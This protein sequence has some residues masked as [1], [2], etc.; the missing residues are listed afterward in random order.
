M[1]IMQE[2]VALN[3]TLFYRGMLGFQPR[4]RKALLDFQQQAVTSG[5]LARTTF[6][7]LNAWIDRRLSR[8]VAAH[9]K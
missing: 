1:R 5:P 9:F 8:D 4:Q 7:V 6:N 2:R 3:A